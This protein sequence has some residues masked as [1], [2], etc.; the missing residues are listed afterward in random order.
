MVSCP[1]ETPGSMPRPVALYKCWQN[2]IKCSGLTLTHCWDSL[3]SEQFGLVPV[4]ASQQC[5][6]GVDQSLLGRKRRWCRDSSVSLC[7]GP[8]PG[9]RREEADREPTG[10]GHISGAFPRGFF[11]QSQC[12]RGVYSPGLLGQEQPLGW[13]EQ[14]GNPEMAAEVTQLSVPS[15]WEAKIGA[16]RTGQES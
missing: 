15:G 8:S 4:P 7:P 10:R 6:Q 13:L 5:P 9:R 1:P 2:W 3:L 14:L 16:G 12:R 11:S